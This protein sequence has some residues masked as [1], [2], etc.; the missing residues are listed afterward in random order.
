MIVYKSQVEGLTSNEVLLDQSRALNE[1]QPFTPQQERVIDQRIRAVV[2]PM[3]RFAGDLFIAVR[4]EINALGAE[5]NELRAETNALRTETRD[6]LNQMY[7]FCCYHFFPIHFRSK[8]RCFVRSRANARRHNSSISQ[9]VQLE[10]VIDDQG[11]TPP[12][13]PVGLTKCGYPHLGGTLSLFNAV[14]HQP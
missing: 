1:A 12:S 9:D 4:A 8:L 2:W 11:G 7:M 14:A 5:T 13:F 6:Q 3:A 10:P